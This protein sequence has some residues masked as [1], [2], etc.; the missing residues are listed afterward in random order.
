M[1]FFTEK[2]SLQITFRE[3]CQ[4]RTMPVLKIKT[5]VSTI[6]IRIFSISKFKFILYFTNSGHFN[7]YT[8]FE[9]N[10]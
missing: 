5:A 4:N 6:L 8:S 9:K 1:I 10:I 2:V 3:K 7:M